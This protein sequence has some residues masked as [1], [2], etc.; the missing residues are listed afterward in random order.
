MILPTL[1]GSQS[2]WIDYL[3]ARTGFKSELHEDGGFVEVHFDHLPSRFRTDSKP[4]TALRDEVLATRL[5]E[6][7]LLEYSVPLGKA[8]GRVDVVGRIGNTSW[9][10]ECKIP[11]SANSTMDV[12]QVGQAIGQS[13]ILAY[14]Y[15]Q[16]YKGN[17]SGLIM[18]A[19]CT[20]TLGSGS[21][22]VKRVCALTGVTVFEV[23]PPVAR[24]GDVLLAK[25][26]YAFR[27]YYLDESS[28]RRFCEDWSSTI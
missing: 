15:K 13:L 10:V 2:W 3:C 21:Q 5:F 20:E 14:A 9:V 4:E 25:Y 27:V 1:I 8:K 19:I 7:P 6:D 22:V 26:E 24:K 16:Q 11:G 17:L 28:P 12:H 23:L 18:P